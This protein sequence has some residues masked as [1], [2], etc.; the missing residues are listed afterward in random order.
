MFLGGG[1]RPGCQAPKVGQGCL[2]EHVGVAGRGSGLLS[3]SL[4][5]VPGPP[6]QG[7]GRKPGRPT[8]VT[9]SALGPGVGGSGRWWGRRSWV[10]GCPPTQGPHSRRFPA[11]VLP[12]LATRGGP[13]STHGPGSG[14]RRAV[15]AVCRTTRLP[16]GKRGPL[17]LP[18]DQ[19]VQ[20]RRKEAGS[21]PGAW[22][23]LG[24]RHLW[25]QPRWGREGP[26]RSELVPPEERCPSHGLSSRGGRATAPSPSTRRFPSP[27]APGAGGQIRPAS[28]GWN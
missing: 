13:S 28:W 9:R 2:R 25:P 21:A 27:R 14:D 19:I 4:W 11:G 16:I 8:Q 15:G 17:P 7:R 24:R 20:R 10:P 1:G 6:D 18:R 23:F 26:V 5:A 3:P 22:G 12:A